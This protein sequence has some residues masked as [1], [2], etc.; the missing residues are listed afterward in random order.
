MAPSG[1]DYQ[2]LNVCNAAKDQCY[3][4]GWNH[5][6][7][8]T[9]MSNLYTWKYLLPTGLHHFDCDV[10]CDGCQDGVS[11]TPEANPAYI[12]P[13]PTSDPI[14]APTAP[15]APSDNDDQCSK[16][17]YAAIDGCYASG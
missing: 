10:A 1:N 7:C 6:T 15:M 14:P 8:L 11:C 16:V 5:Q 4:S 13:R 17:C 9:T 2:C 12:D 3:A